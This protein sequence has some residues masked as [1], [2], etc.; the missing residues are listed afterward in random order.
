MD[1]W[2]ALKMILAGTLFFIFELGCGIF[3]ILFAINLF[4]L[5][6]ATQISCSLVLG[7]LFCLGIS[8]GIYV[9]FNM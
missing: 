8:T 2:D 9:V 7:L 5:N 6:L 1:F 3:A 4:D